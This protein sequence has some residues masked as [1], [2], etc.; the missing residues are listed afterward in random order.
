MRWT[1]TSWNCSDCRTEYSALLALLTGA[2][3]FAKCSRGSQRSLL[4][5][6]HNK[7]VQETGRSGPKLHKS[8]YAWNWTRKHKRLKLDRGQAYDPS[9]WLTNVSELK[10]NLRTHR[11]TGMTHDTSESEETVTGL[12]RIHPNIRRP[13]ICPMRHKKTQEKEH[14]LTKLNVVQFWGK[15]LKMEA[16]I[17]SQGHENWSI[18]LF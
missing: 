17:Y 1:L 5:G 13:H 4:V 16:H 18:S 7:T 6:L 3:R 2:H 12:Y 11:L 8:K 9:K 15:K 14:Y 10:S